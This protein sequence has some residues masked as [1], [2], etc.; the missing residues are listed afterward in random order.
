M[1]VDIRKAYYKNSYSMET[2]LAEAFLQF[3][4]GAS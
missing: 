3:V 2:K 1:A 4:Q